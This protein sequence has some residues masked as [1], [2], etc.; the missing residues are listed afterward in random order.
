MSPLHDWAAR[1]SFLLLLALLPLLWIA[2]KHSLARMT[3]QQQRWSVILRV[4]I[5]SL[6]VLALAGLRLPWESRDLA[7]VFA[8]DRSA[9]V[10]PEAEKAGLAFIHE[11]LKSKRQ[12]D[13]T[14]FV[15]FAETGIA[16]PAPST[17]KPE[18]WPAQPKKNA[19]DIGKALTFS[20]AIADDGKQRRIVL[21]S[22]G[23]DTGGHAPEAAAALK[24]AGVE[25][26][27]VPLLNPTTPEV[28]V[29]KL[30]IPREL[31]DG[32][33]FDATVTIR[34]NVETPGKVRLFSGG[35]VVGEQSVTLK[36]GRTP[37][38]FRSIRPDRTSATYEVEV[39]PEK[40][41]QIE[42]NR[43]QATA[44]Q[45]G[46]PRI[47][48]I[49]PSPDRLQPL[50]GV[51]AAERIKAETRPLSGLP[52]TMEDLQAYDALILSDVSALHLTR[53]QMKLYAQWVKEFG[54]GFAMLGGENSYGVGGYFRTPLEA[55]L[56][57]RMEND[58]RAEAPTVAVMII[59]DSSGSMSAMT[60]GQSK[61]SLAN[62]GAA[63]ALEVL[64]AK[65]LL[66]V[67]AVDTKIHQIAPLARHGNKGE[68]AQNIMRITAG[69]GGI[70]VYTSLIEAYNQLKNVNAKI[71][72][73]I[74]FSDAAD[75]EEKAAGEMSDGSKIPGTALELAAAVVP[76]RITT[77]VVALGQPNDKDVNFLKQLATTG[78]G[79]FY[80]TNDALSLPQIFTTETMR[81]A[82]SSM[83]EDPVLPVPAR[84]SPVLEGI[85][86]NE[87]P[88]LLGYNIT[89]L[90]P[91]A[92]LI[93]A[94]EKGDPLLATWQYGLGRVAA[95]TSDAKSRWG[96]E[97]LGW[98]GYGKFWA[99]LTRSLMR[100]G[101]AKGGFQ[102]ETQPSADG[103]HLQVTVDATEPD[104]SFRNQLPLTVGAILPDGTKET[105]EARQIAPGRY[106]ASIAISGTGTTWVHVLPGDA[107]KDA[108]AGSVF[109]HTPS[110]PAEFLS[111]DTDE[112]AL[113]T[114]AEAA[115]GTFTP[116]PERIFAP[117]EHGIRRYRDLTPFFLGLALLLFPID[118]WL[119]RKTWN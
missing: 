37:L 72:H 80:L 14:A 115:S 62:Q 6:L 119:R 118:I 102:I 78:A 79:R 34:S 95:F 45:R 54:G 26:L 82:Q 20:S 28:L 57:V 11:A 66:G 77:S 23:H 24:A 92:D 74:L 35:F 40:D 19:T 50:T 106:A 103:N 110:Y 83:V 21:L 7:V 81:V 33:P 41:T 96:A 51:L 2:L 18:P 75:A 38:L 4:A 1:P 84:K 59:L 76:A 3:P 36:P 90:K 44:F 39:I 31:R 104:G 67:M 91:T 100:Q 97:W 16:L 73:V 56:P 64:Q 63:L 47:L 48:L 70:Y 113:K 25:L 29:E 49:D 65:D 88:L 42:N 43:A 69:G 46:E 85:N 98:P 108:A 53:S 9:S 68:V 15:G 71:K 27:V 61:M 105:A 8:I 89:K 32:E 116:A 109:G 30:E 94:T 99:Q 60:A 10:T 55:I 107:P 5:L 86:W 93:L 117:P 58:D 52:T 22:D 101:G 13:E 17:E 87:A 112:A 111:N 114:L 12:G